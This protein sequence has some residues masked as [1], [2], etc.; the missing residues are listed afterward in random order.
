M[1]RLC[2]HGGA[3]QSSFVDMGSV[4]K[5]LCRHMGALQSSFVDIE[6]VTKESL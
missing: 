3:L 6:S 5:K 1:K 4:S 2:R